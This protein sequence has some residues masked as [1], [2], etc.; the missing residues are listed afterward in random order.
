[1]TPGPQRNFW[2]MGFHFLTPIIH[3]LSKPEPNARLVAYSMIT[4]TWAWKTHFDKNP[5]KIVRKNAK[6]QLNLSKLTFDKKNWLNFLELPFS[7][8]HRRPEARPDLLSKIFFPLPRYL[9]SI[10]IWPGQISTPESNFIQLPASYTI[11]AHLLFTV[12]WQ[13]GERALGYPTEVCRVEGGSVGYPS[14]LSPHGQ[15]TTEW[16]CAKVSDF[17][18]RWVPGASG[19]GFRCRQFVKEADSRG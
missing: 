7:S 8:R 19:I 5:K 3:F 9:A 13:W 6:T 16:K 4:H 10:C 17:T 11:L 18:G 15:P 14:A 12:G 2:N 1:M